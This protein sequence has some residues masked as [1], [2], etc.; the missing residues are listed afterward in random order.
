M[1][2]WVVITLHGE[3]DLSRVEEIDLIFQSRRPRPGIGLIVDLSP[4]T[5]MDSSGI[6]LLMRAEQDLLKDGS[7]MRLVAPRGP[8]Q[9]V[10]EVAGLADRWPLFHTLDMAIEANDGQLR[11]A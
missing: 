2:D 1:V 3:I 7:R 4:V 5:F 6:G 10:M 8:A 9:R 11:T